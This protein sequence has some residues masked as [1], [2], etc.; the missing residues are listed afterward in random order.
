MCFAANDPNADATLDAARRAAGVDHDRLVRI[1]DVGRS[2]EIA[3]FVEEAL[4][5]AHTLTHLLEQG[6]LPS[7]EA[8]RIAGETA[9]GLEAARGRGLHH[10]QLTPAYVLRTGDGSVKVSGL[11]TAAALAGWTTSA[12]PRPP[13]P[14]PLASWP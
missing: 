13:A 3:F 14:T 1:L 8:R 10:L 7:E 4:Y 12:P 11:A 6:G 9:T 5:E 2:D